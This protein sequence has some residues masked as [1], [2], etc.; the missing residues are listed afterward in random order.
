MEITWKKI[1]PACLQRWYWFAVSLAVC[2]CIGAVYLYRSVPVYHVAST[3]LVRESE[4]DQRSGNKINMQAAGNEKQVT[5]EIAIL[6]SKSIMQQVIEQ[7]NLQVTYKKKDRIWQEQYPQHDLTLTI[8]QEPLQ[9]LRIWVTV[10]DN[11]YKVV[12]KAGLTDRKKVF[13]TT[14][15]QPIETCCGPVR[16][17]AD[18][19]LQSGDKYMLQVAPM[20]SL[21]EAYGQQIQVNRLAKESKIIKLDAHTACPQKAADMIDKMVELYNHEAFID[22]NIIA[23]TAA[24]FIADRLALITGELA[25]IEAEVEEYKRTHHIADLDATATLYLE[26]SDKYQRQTADIKT[27]IQLVEFLR[28]FVVNNTEDNMIPANIG[29]NDATLNTLIQEYNNLILRKRQILFTATDLNPMIVKLDSQAVAMRSNIIATIDKVSQGLTIHYNDISSRQQQYTKQL[30]GMPERERHYM[31]IK[32]QQ[33]LKEEL[34]LYLHERQEENSLILASTV[35]SAKVVDSALIDP[36]PVSPKA[37][38]VL[39]FCL[40]FGVMLPFAAIYL[41]LLKQQWLP[42]PSSQDAQIRNWNLRWF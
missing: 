24:T 10:K 33:E 2:L 36:T 13:V 25:T 15:D 12:S 30:E 41:I 26:T 5:D 11:G 32:R 22:K 6:T 29:V 39:L 8:D 19:T 42:K 3:L 14:L 28:E 27:Q 20:P 23:E 21:I 37:K 38:L 4:N 18:K 9:T 40:L 16:I 34:Y 7:L 35:L 17:T 31:E 1:L